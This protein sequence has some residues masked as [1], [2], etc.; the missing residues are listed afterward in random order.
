MG[1][2]ARM[3]ILVASPL[4]MV[5]EPTLSRSFEGSEVT[6]A[7]DQL[8]VQN[9]IEENLRFDVVIA[10]LIWS[11]PR[12]EFRFDGLDVV[13][14]VHAADRRTPV[15]LATQG[16]SIEQDHL[17]EAYR[18]SDDV[19]GVHDKPAGIPPLLTA[20][21]DAANGGC[22][23]RRPAMPRATSL[24]ELFAGGQGGTAGR[25]AGAIASGRTW[26]TP[27][28]AQAAN[29][30]L[31]TAEAVASTLLG[32]VIRIRGEHGPIGEITPPVVYRWCGIHA[33]YLMSWCRR[34]GHA[35]V[36]EPPASSITA[37]GIRTP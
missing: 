27:S 22:Q 32:P 16:H 37:T 12:L 15:L 6:V 4:G 33:R 26:D 34:H 1:K 29:V 3:R 9:A 17:D 5:I 21:H 20:I 11:D 7:L 36:L 18:R 24:H 23:F 2:Y 35:D 19:V 8:G 10:D 30:G 25:L 14:M 13:D 28:L 31:D